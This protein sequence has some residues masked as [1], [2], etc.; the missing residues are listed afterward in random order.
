MDIIVILLNFFSFLLIWQFLGYPSLMAIVALKSKHKNK[1]YS[2]NPFVSII[3]PT[4]NEEKV[5]KKRI[6]NLFDLDWPKNRYEIIIVDSGS[7]DN[8]VGIVKNIIRKSKDNKQSFR[9]VEEGK[10]RGKAS[11]IMLGKKYAKGEIVLL[12]DANTIFHKDVLKEIMPHFKDLNVGAVSGRY[13][14]SNPAKELPYSESFYWEIEHISF[15]GES[16]LD[17]M[18]SV[19]GTLSA[20][21][22]E[23]MNLSAETVGEDLDMTIQV[24]QSGYKVK[25]EPNAI[26][27]EPAATNLEDQ[28]KQRKRTSLATIKN[29]FRHLD[30]FIPPS[31][32]YSFLIFPSHK[33]L[34]MF[35]PFILL[36][37]LFLYIISWDISVIIT[38]FVL[39]SL[40]FVG[41]FALLMFLR[42][43]FTKLDKI[44]IN[45]SSSLIPKIIYYVLLNEYL[46]LLA[47]KDFLLKKHPILWEKA[48]ST[49]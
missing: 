49:R 30:Y 35:S 34:T 17:S 6:M 37:I 8:T 38:H 47:W 15:L 1:E 36:I 16:S 19:I 10:R 12:S 20:W 26:A 42:T 18:S 39:S 27:Y 40:T 9:L 5:I 11:A 48:E 43:R 32:L 41:V 28:I 13:V 2:Y 4:Y 44:K 23:L 29:I 24:R 31:D 14:I 25:Y 3:I 46:I 45:F 7:I 21:R 22:K 33:V